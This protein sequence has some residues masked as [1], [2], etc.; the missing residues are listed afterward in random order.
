MNSREKQNLKKNLN[1]IKDN[2]QEK[3]NMEQLINVKVK[4]I[5]LNMLLNELKKKKDKQIFK[6]Y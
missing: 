6:K 1:L 3:V 5:I 2:F 4:L